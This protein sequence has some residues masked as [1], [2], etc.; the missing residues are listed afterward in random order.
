MAFTCQ[1][2]L[3]TL[4]RDGRIAVTCQTCGNHWAE[5][6][7]EM[8]ET[9]RL[10]AQFMDLL[11]FE[12]RCN[13]A[14]CGGTVD[15]D[16]EGKPDVTPYTTKVMTLPRPKAERLP[17]PVKAVVKRRPPVSPQYGV[18][19]YDLPMALPPLRPTQPGRIVSV[20][21]R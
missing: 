12:T 15:F 16:Y 6:V 7:Q 9:R 14:F 1:P 8:V 3:K 17:Y 21:G 10:G 18:P 19:Q 20:A 2:Q 5:S 13:D 11:E 4:P